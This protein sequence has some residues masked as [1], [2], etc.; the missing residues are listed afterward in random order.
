Q[1]EV[2][3]AGAAHREVLQGHAA[4]GGEVA[5]GGAADVEVGDG[6]AF[7]CVD[8]GDILVSVEVEADFALLDLE[9]RL[10]LILVGVGLAERVEGTADDG[11]GGSAAYVAGDAA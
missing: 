10:P 6:E 9:L 2:L 11:P 5:D 4:E 3:E 7:Q 8:V 1:F